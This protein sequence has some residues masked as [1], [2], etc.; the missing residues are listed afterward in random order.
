MNSPKRSFLSGGQAA[1]NSSKAPPCLISSAPKSSP[2]TRL[3]LELISIIIS[4]AD[5]SP[6]LRSWHAAALHNRSIYNAVILHQWAHVTVAAPDLLPSPLEKLGR[7]ERRAQT[8]VIQVATTRAHHSIL[9][10]HHIRTLTIDLNNV[11]LKHSDRLAGPLATGETLEHSLDRLFPHLH[12]LR[13]IDVLGDAPQELIDSVVG[14][15]PGNNITSLRIRL[16]R[17]D[18]GRF[19]TPGRREKCQQVI[20]QLD[21]L[22]RLKGLRE[23]EIWGLK[24]EEAPRLA[25]AL[26]Q[27]TALRRLVI[28]TDSTWDCMLL[29]R[30]NIRSPLDTFFE[31]VF[32][33]HDA[34]T[35]CGLPTTL[36][37]LELHD[38]YCSRFVLL[39]P[40]STS[41]DHF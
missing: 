2:W 19:S 6:T 9:P 13:R 27:T 21:K 41:A 40:S 37:F 11:R 29:A 18:P 8:N 17:D 24:Q 16:E 14:L 36:E 28:A 15:I 3:P 7:P 32:R 35:C 4:Y 10:A 5:D 20:L 1:N 34:E 23:L 22:G 12:S 25:Q 33:S 30:G 26:T 39:T 38:Y 31:H